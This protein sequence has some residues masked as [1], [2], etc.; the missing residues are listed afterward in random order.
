MDYMKLAK[1]LLDIRVKL[2][3]VPFV[4]ILSKMERGETFVLNYLVTHDGPIHPKNLSTAMAVSTARIATL[5]NKLEEKNQV[6]R[7]VDPDDKRQ[8]IVV[9]TDEGREKILQHR[10]EILPDIRDFLEELGAEDA[11]A[12]LNGPAHGL[13]SVGSD[14]IGVNEIIQDVAG[15]GVV[16]AGVGVV[17]IPQTVP[18]VDI[19]ISYFRRSQYPP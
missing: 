8:L 5:L 19:L 3:Q 7:Y 11:Q 14:L 12:V 18:Q 6:R 1:E 16:A 17:G 13:E 15:A 9:L 2:V 4:Q 10:A